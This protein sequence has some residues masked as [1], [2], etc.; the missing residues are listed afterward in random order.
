[1]KKTLCLTLCIVIIFGL[2]TVTTP[3][4]DEIK[5]VLN[6]EQLVFDVQPII[7]EG[8]TLVPF[9][10]IFE[11]LNAKVA[12][13][14]SF[15]LVTATKGNVVIKLQINNNIA[16]INGIDVILDVPAKIVNDRTLVPLRFI[17]ESLGLD[18]DWDG[19]V[20]TVIITGAI[21]TTFSSTAIPQLDPVS[22]PTA[23]PSPTA[24]PTPTVTSK[25]NDNPN[26]N[27]Q[28]GNPTSVP[29][30]V[31]TNNTPN[32]TATI[33]PTPT[34][35]QFPTATPTPTIYRLYPIYR[36]NNNDY[37]M[38]SSLDSFY[39]VDNKF[40]M[41]LRA[42]SNLL[43]ISRNLYD[44]VESDGHNS[45][46]FTDF[47]LRYRNSDQV[48]VL[49]ETVPI[50]PISYYNILTIKNGDNSITWNTSKSETSEY[51]TVINGSHYISF[52]VLKNNLDISFDYE[53]DTE[54]GY[55][56]FFNVSSTQPAIPSPSPNPSMTINGR[57]FIGIIQDGK[58]YYNMSE[59]CNFI[60]TAFN[61]DTVRSGVRSTEWAEGAIFSISYRDADR[62]DVITVYHDNPCII[63][64]YDTVYMERTFFEDNILPAYQDLIS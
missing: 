19:N 31:P 34:I 38:E 26:G 32:P 55:I 12:W 15:G 36:L 43:S 47:R 61:T 13:E 45:F 52:E 30:N 23:A 64:H 6:N 48:F 27:N 21:G 49:F 37:S 58:E 9:R 22:T 11:A 10:A 40:Y 14:E 60:M 1:M 18:V 54:N 51:F 39:M 28:S 57:T 16:T 17:G 7:I 59:L 56:Y 44:I 4:S 29:T 8:R 42:T 50:N 20:R 63:T 25:P 35:P 2:F 62:V 5:V 41:G 24:I 3:A 46:A 53:I 33:R